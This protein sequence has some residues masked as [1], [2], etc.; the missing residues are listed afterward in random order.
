MT[1]IDN[2]ILIPATQ[3]RIWAIVSDLQQNPQW[4]VDCQGVSILSTAKSGQGTRWRSVSRNGREQVLE[5]TAWYDRLGYEYRIVDG[6]NLASNKGLLRL[7]EIPE[8]TIVQWTF[9]YEPTGFLSG[10]QDTLRTRRKLEAEIVDSLRQ[11][12]R[13]LSNRAQSGAFETKALIREAPDVEARAHYQ[14]RHPSNVEAMGTGDTAASGSA[15][16]ARA[17]SADHIPAPDPITQ[18]NM[19]QVAE[20]DN[21]EGDTRPNPAIAQPAEPIAPAQTT[22][23]QPDDDA[24]FRPPTPTVLSTPAVPAPSALETTEPD[25]QAS[26][27]P[28]SMPPAFEQPVTDSASGQAGIP[29]PAETAKDFSPGV[30]AEATQTDSSPPAPVTVEPVSSIEQPD[31]GSTQPAPEPVTKDEAAPASASTSSTPDAPTLSDSPGMIDTREVDTARISIFDLF[32]IPKPSETQEMQR[33]DLP[34]FSDSSELLPA[35]VDDVDKTPEQTPLAEPAEPETITSPASIAETPIATPEAATTAPVTSPRPA[36]AV[37]LYAAP[38]TGRIG[39]RW[40]LRRTAVSLRR[41]R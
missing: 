24:A 31:A 15:A 5:I 11:L 16:P 23:H 19:P 28:A 35:V 22:S 36:P 26:V 9:T 37:S 10:V 33:I 39:L 18:L 14:P 30:A 6:T 13:L 38:Y 41:P 34:Q 4:Q 25:E 40:R 27:E 32:G 2:R 7:Q 3:D 29:T 21:A 8:G 1:L 20:P 12:Y 17:S